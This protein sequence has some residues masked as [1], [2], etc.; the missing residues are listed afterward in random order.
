MRPH[1]WNAPRVL[2]GLGLL[3]LT[4]GPI[5][6]WL[7]SG[8]SAYLAFLAAPVAFAAL[9]VWVLR[10]PPVPRRDAVLTALEIGALVAGLGVAIIQWRWGLSQ[11]SAPWFFL[12]LSS[13]GILG[14]LAMHRHDKGK[15]ALPGAPSA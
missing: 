10:A 13:G 3:A 4:A 1:E 6:G 5:Q 2:I 11:A 12:L 7:A 8:S 14:A 9:A 15:H